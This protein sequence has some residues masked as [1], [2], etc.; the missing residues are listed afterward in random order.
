M[1]AKTA[2]KRQPKKK[3]VMAFD[4]ASIDLRKDAEAGCTLHLI[5][6]R[7]MK[8]IYAGG[9]ESKPCE[10]Y[11]IGA[12]ADVVQQRSQEI[13]KRQERVR[14]E[15]IHALKAQGKTD[16]EVKVLAAPTPQEK[17]QDDADML[18]AATTGWNNI[19]FNGNEVF[20][21]SLVTEMYATLDWARQQ[22]LYKVLQPS[23]FIQRPEQS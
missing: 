13:M 4:L 22:A 5:D 12:H 7:T 19:S 1:T 8:P 23:N 6:P 16:E 9:D 18:A 14:M 20:S 2:T 21:E 3:V 11:L 17:R 15:K 10:L